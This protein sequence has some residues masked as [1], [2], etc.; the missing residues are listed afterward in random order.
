[1]SGELMNVSGRPV[2]TEAIRPACVRCDMDIVSVSR[3]T[4]T[5]LPGALRCA[6]KRALQHAADP[7]NQ[8]DYN[9]YI[10]DE[11]AIVATELW[12]LAA[13]L[14][15]RL[16]ALFEVKGMTLWPPPGGFEVAEQPPA[17]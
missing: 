14:D 12:S 11:W 1:M 8:L 5:G 7:L 6:S 13:A 9:P 17:A 15:R 4:P 16:G 2:P 10:A 3:T